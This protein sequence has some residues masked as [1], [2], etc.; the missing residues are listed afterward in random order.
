MTPPA[1]CI[2]LPT[3]N[4]IV[5]VTIISDTITADASATNHALVVIQDVTLGPN[6]YER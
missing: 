2:H 3:D 4:P 5:D 6:A 1:L